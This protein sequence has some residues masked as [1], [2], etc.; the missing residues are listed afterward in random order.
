LVYYILKTLKQQVGEYLEAQRPYYGD[1]EVDDNLK[2]LKD[3]NDDLSNIDSLHKILLLRLI[4]DHPLYKA[5]EASK[6]SET[7]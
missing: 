2:I 7:E 1:E 3:Q 5:I 6:T 4:D